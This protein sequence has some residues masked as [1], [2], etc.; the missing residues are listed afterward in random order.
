MAS[1]ITKIGHDSLHSTLRV[2]GQAGATTDHADWMRGGERGE[3]ASLLVRFIDE[4]MALAEMNPYEMTVAA[5]LTA[6][7]R[8]N[9]EELDLKNPFWTPIGE[10]QFARLAN[11]APA[12]P[13]GKH[14]YRFFRIRFGEGDDGVAKTLEVHCARIHHVFGVKHYWRSGQLLSGKVEYHGEPVERLRLLNG[15]HTHK[16]C[17]EW[18]VANFDR[19]RKRNSVAAVRSAKSLADELLVA[20]WMFPEVV[21][22]MHLKNLPALFAAGYEVNVPGCG[23]ETWRHT[24][25]VYFDRL[26]HQAS[27]QVFHVCDARSGFSVPELL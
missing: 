5:Q 25:G 23:E 26:E 21:R 19:H 13:K 18:V 27:L 24:M 11:S 22:D 4:Q 17:I 2:L 15:N 8:A 12:W 9:E 7:R 3:N 16:A 6:L 10:E 14:V 20:A 1:P